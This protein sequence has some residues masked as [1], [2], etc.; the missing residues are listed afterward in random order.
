MKYC[1]HIPVLNPFDCYD[2]SNQALDYAKNLLGKY[3]NVNFIKKNA[4]RLALK[5]DINKEINENYDLIY[6]TGLYDYLDDDIATKLTSNLYKLLKDKGRILISNYRGKEFNP[7]AYLMEWSAE[8]YLVYRTENNF[9]NIFISSGFDR[10]AIRTIIQDCEVM[11]Y[12]YAGK[13]KI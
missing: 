6:S 10:K 3:N 12:V 9:R 7:T 4:L 5:K 8:W 2:F 11:Q 1:H 13:C